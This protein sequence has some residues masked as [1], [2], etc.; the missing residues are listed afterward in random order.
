MVL[1]KKGFLKII[2]FVVCFTKGPKG[3]KNPQERAEKRQG[4]SF[5]NLPLL[6]KL[7]CRI[8]PQTLEILHR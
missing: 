3:H 1:E 6:C 2:F 5:A 7:Y 8:I 4:D